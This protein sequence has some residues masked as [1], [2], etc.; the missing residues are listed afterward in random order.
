MNTSLI[1]VKLDMV[2]SDIAGCRQKMTEA[3]AAVTSVYNKLAAI[4]TAYAEMITAIND[5]GY[6][7]ALADVQKAQLAALVTEFTALAT[8]VEAAQTALTSGVTEY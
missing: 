6:T 4:P 8:A 1:V 5:V 7:G 3:R 2:S